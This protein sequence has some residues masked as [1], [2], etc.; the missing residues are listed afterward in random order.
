MDNA[1]DK[2]TETATAPISAK[3]LYLSPFRKY[4]KVFI[5]PTVAH[6]RATSDTYL[7]PYN[8]K[9]KLIVCRHA[10]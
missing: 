5:Y 8:V 9:N 1:T 10:I 3:A 4:T 2:V 7:S 6:I